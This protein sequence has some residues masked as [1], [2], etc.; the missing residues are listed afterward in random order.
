MVWWL[1]DNKKTDYELIKEEKEFMEAEVLLNELG[2]TM[3]N[4]DGS[5][6]TAEQVKKEIMELLQKEIGDIDQDG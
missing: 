4:K 2:A 1:M 5:L 3:V 6:K